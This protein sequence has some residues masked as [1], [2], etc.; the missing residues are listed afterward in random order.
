MPTGLSGDSIS[1][2]GNDQTVQLQLAE[3]RVMNSQLL[4]YL[5]TN[6]VMDN[7]D[8]LRNDEAFALQIPTP[9]PGIGR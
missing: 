3:L 9:L 1:T 4:K 5:G 2:T 7:L 6:Q 8:T